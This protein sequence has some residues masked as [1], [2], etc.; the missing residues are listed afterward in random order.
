MSVPPRP[1]PDLV[2]P[3]TAGPRRLRPLAAERLLVVFYQEDATPTCTTQLCSFR[4]DFDLL[5]ELGTE[6]V[7]VSADSVDIH[8]AFLQ[9]L[10]GLPFALLSDSAGEAARSF[11]VWDAESQRSQRAVF[12]LD[13][14]G[15]ILHAS[16]P[17][18]PLNLAQYEAVF[19]ALGLAS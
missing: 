15:V 5:Q 17:Y 12:V 14:A 9:R 4:D 6:V 7:G 8:R 11:G 1:G 16:V 13:R 3:G 2:L 19:R 18:T 10:G